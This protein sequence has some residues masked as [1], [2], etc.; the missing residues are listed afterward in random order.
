MKAYHDGD[1]RIG[2]A[3]ALMGN[4][5]DMKPIVEV[6]PSLG[7]VMPVARVRTKSQAV[8]RLLEIVKQRVGTENPVH[9]MVEHTSS[10]D[11][12]E[13]LKQTVRDQFNCVELLVCEFKPVAALITGPKLLGLSFYS[14]TT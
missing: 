13:R 10:P 7:V 5:L 12:A 4:M 6:P 1:W 2:K 8:K 11:E 14:E 3:Q 9:M